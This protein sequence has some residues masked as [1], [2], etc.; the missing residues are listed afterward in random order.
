MAAG[1]ELDEKAIRALLD[2]CAGDWEAYQ[3]R[4]DEIDDAH[5]MA[6]EMEYL[7]ISTRS[8]RI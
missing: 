4:F 2:T 8:A 3:D 6:G 7:D 1:D 5:Q